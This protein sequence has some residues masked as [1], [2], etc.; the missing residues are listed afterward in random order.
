M[1]AT[2]QWSMPRQ[3]F[4]VLL[5]GFEWDSDERQYESFSDVVAY[6]VR[7]ASTVGVMM[8]LVMG[9][10]APATLARACDLGVAF[11]L[12][13]IARDVGE[14]ARNGKVYLPS[15]WLR[16]EGLSRAGLV[17][18]PKPSAALSR[19]VDRM[20]RAADQ[21]YGSAEVG[22]RLLPASCRAAVQAAHLIYRAVGTVL[23]EKH[24]LDSVSSRARTS[25]SHKLRLVLVALA[26]VKLLWPAQRALQPG[27]WAATLARYEAFKEYAV[28]VSPF[29]DKAAPRGGA[30]Q[31]KQLEVGPDGWP[32]IA[33]RRTEN[34]AAP[35]YETP[36]VPKLE[37]LKAARANGNVG[38][39]VVAGCITFGWV[40][41][42]LHGL[43]MGSGSAA[44]PAWQ[45]VLQ[46]LLTTFLYTGLFITAHDAMHG[47]VCP[48]SRALNDV[49]G[50]FCVRAFAMFSYPKLLAAHWQHHRH[51]A[52]ERDPDYHGAAGP[53]FWQWYG[54]FML[55]Y[56]TPAQLALISVAYNV[57]AFGLGVPHSALLLYWVLPSLL[58][59][60]QLFYF[61][62]FLPHRPPD[63]ASVPEHTDKHRSRSNDMPTWLSLLTCYHFGYHWEHHEYPYVPWWRLP[64]V[65]DARLK[66]R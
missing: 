27:H 2:Q 15:A 42:M 66:Q 63:G 21:I 47:L 49:V 48:G 9:E 4:D 25:S 30:P 51:P 46:I 7:V 28:L 20:L 26:Q 29:Y 53:G 33:G 23:R 55:E 40:A 41:C 5:E 19:V 45:A 12:T 64:G 61:G 32:S 43:W 13:N 37:Y 35:L 60:V 39:L 36:A 44:V 56:M 50:M 54:N 31:W 14:D 22:V 6:C 62:T 65:R 58:S 59:S 52:S 3:V 38:G 8:T 1:Q 34:L 16:D 10:R 18:D 24:G 17:A 57:M 11:Q